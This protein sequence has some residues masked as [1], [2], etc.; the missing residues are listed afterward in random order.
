[1]TNEQ[2]A[3]FI[4]Q[5]EANDLTY[6]L[7]ERVKHLMF[8]ICGQ[9][10]GRY[11]ERFAACGVELSD[12][13]QECYPAFLVALRSFKPA[14]DNS[15]ASY[16][17][18]PIK[19]ACARLLGIR[20]KDRQNKQPLD[21]CTS[22]DVP[23]NSE[24]DAEI[25]L[26]A[27]IRDETA[28][29]AFENALNSIQ[30]EQTREVLTKALSRLTKPLRDVIMLYYF[31]G[32]TQEAIAEQAG[33]SGECIRQ[34]KNQALRKLRAMP[35]VQML[36]EEQRIEKTLHFSSRDNSPAY[37]Q[38]QEKIARILKRGDYLSYGKKQAIMYDCLVRAFLNGCA[39]Y[40]G[41]DG[42]EGIPPMGEGW[43]F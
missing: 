17:K 29:Q 3:G 11:S 32:M 28:E 5:G 42:T 26:V 34:R 24:E 14:E 33:V 6:V 27:A 1:M 31:E 16:L 19:N 41:V 8:K 10:Y 23:L 30:D 20:N 18:Y 15:F 40:T 37:Y 43:Q 21:N 7:W 38:A 25:T 2:L 13:R 39:E 9:Y 22:L 35:D 36:R 12:L 4:L